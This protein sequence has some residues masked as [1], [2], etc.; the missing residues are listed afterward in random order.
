MDGTSVTLGMSGRKP[1]YARV[2]VNYLTLDQVIGKLL[3]LQVTIAAESGINSEI[4]PEDD[5]SLVSITVQYFVPKTE[6]DLELEVK[7]KE[8]DKNYRRAQY[9][10][11]KKEFEG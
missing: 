2:L 11:L 5:N 6:R 4:V 1:K 10:Q 8:R 3:D 9:E 7:Q